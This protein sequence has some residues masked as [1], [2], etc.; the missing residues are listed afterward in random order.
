MVPG[1]I[2]YIEFLLDLCAF[3]D[4]GGALERMQ[5]CILAEGLKVIFLLLSG[6]ESSLVQS[7]CESCVHLSA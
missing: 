6:R 4:V 7:I 2:P 1:Q 5:I 3:D